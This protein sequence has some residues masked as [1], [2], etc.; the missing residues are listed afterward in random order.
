MYCHECKTYHNAWVSSFLPLLTGCK[1]LLL[2]LQA[3][4]NKRQHYHHF[5]SSEFL[6]SRYLS[7]I[8]EKTKPHHWFL[9]CNSCI[10][11]CLQ[12][13]FLLAILVVKHQEYLV[14]VE[15][16]SAF[17][18]NVIIQAFTC[19]NGVG[20]YLLCITSV[21]RQNLIVIEI[22]DLL[23]MQMF[24]VPLPTKLWEPLILISEGEIVVLMACRPHSPLLRYVYITTGSCTHIWSPRGVRAF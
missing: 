11:S 19:P 24:A 13:S 17:L 6:C 21:T 18:V 22:W 4:C 23:R 9:L 14:Y 7:S 20:L 15:C 1:L 2:W 5:L 8:W 10:M 16:D 12:H 3:N